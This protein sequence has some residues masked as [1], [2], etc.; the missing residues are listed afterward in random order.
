MKIHSTGKHVNEVL[1]ISDTEAMELIEIT[2]PLWRKLVSGEE[3]ANLTMGDILL[4][5]ANHEKF[6]L[7]EKCFLCSHISRSFEV[8][9][10]SELFLSG[11]CEGFIDELGLAKK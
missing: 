11:N 8:V 1:G 7:A 6:T 3:G 4:F 2:H 9:I 10:I 5:V